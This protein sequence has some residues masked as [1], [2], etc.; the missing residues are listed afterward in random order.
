M[1]VAAQTSSAPP[2]PLT[3][4]SESSLLLPRPYVLNLSISLHVP[5]GQAQPT[6]PLPPL[7]TEVPAMNVSALCN[8]VYL[9]VLSMEGPLNVSSRLPPKE[10]RGRFFMLPFAP[11]PPPFPL[12]SFLPKLLKKERDGS[13]TANY[14][15]GGLRGQGSIGA[16]V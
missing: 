3:S 5:N 12:L 15:Q 2:L 4:E 10:R 14:V 7:H 1:K 6:D 11:P 16:Q 13:H 9:C 8:A